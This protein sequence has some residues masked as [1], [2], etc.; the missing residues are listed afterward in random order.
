MLSG[1]FE[2]EVVSNIINE[3]MLDDM[4][5]ANVKLMAREGSDA[6]IPNGNE[7]HAAAIYEG[8]FNNVKEKIQIFCNNLDGNVFD[9][10]EVI[11]AFE[12]CLKKNVQVNIVTQESVNETSPFVKTFNN[13]KKQN[14][15]YSM[16]LTTVSPDS[17]LASLK[18]NFTIGDDKMFR[19]EADRN[20]CKATASFNQ[21]SLVK[22]LTQSASFV[23][24][25]IAQNNNPEGAFT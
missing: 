3:F 8:M 17:Q 12:N 23:F 25:P 15:S 24:E 2:Q 10:P 14:A 22:T 18:E 1:N 20:E 9:R 6:Y 11:T 7:V 13:L 4:Y 19:F 21:P 5:R 16:S